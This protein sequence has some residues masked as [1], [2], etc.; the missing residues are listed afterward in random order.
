MNTVCYVNKLPDNADR[1]SHG[2]HTEPFYDGNSDGY[3]VSETE[4]NTKI[5]TTQRRQS[6]YKSIF[7]AIFDT[8]DGFLKPRLV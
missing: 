7:V 2:P 1:W 3:T 8:T 5:L 4:K 6:I